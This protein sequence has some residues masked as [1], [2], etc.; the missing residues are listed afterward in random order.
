MNLVFLK[1]SNKNEQNLKNTSLPKT[2]FF[3]ESVNLNN[4]E[5]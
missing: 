5:K 4:L 3:S 2:A 1:I